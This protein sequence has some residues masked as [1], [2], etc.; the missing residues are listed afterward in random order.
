MSL[1]E[2]RKKVFKK[3]EDI[4][5]YP[6]RYI[7]TIITMFLAKTN[8][9][10]LQITWV[11]LI[12]G[13][14][15]AVLFGFG[16]YNLAIIAFILYL[17]SMI[18]DFVDGEI[19]RYKNIRSEV[20]IWLDHVSDNILLFLI[21]IGIAIGEFQINQDFLILI[22]ALIALLVTAS[23]GV[24][25]ISKRTSEKMKQS[26]AIVLPIKFKY[27]EKFHVGIFV[28]SSLIL[29]I[30]PIIKQVEIIFIIYIVIMFFAMIKSFINRMKLIKK[31]FNE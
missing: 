17:I 28:F 8:V 21:I 5:A 31:E 3:E 16:K 23:T 29:I 18:L 13:I 14:I 22:L 6:F 20:G 19:A 12:I 1:K 10:S 26:K 30:S 4:F 27:V 7:S 11:H 9:S 2:V 24:I 15:S 25:N